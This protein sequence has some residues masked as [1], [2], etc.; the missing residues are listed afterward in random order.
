MLVLIPTLTPIVLFVRLLRPLVLIRFGA[1][2]S[3][4]FGLL[5]FETEIYLCERDAG[6]HGKRVLDLFY[7]LSP[8]CNQQ[9]KKMW[10]RALPVSRLA[11]W[12]YKVN[13]KLPG[14][15]IHV[16]PRC[17]EQERDVHGLLART[18]PHISFTAKEERQGQASLREM[19]IPE[20]DPFV[21]FHARDSAYVAA[22]S[23]TSVSSLLYGFR[24][25]SIRNYVPAAAELA[26]RGCFAV[27]L[28]SVVKDPLDTSNPMIIDYATKHRSDFL[29]VYLGAR[30]RFILCSSNGIFAVPATFRRP[31]AM[32]NYVPLEFVHTW[33]PND[34]FIPRKLWLPHERRYLTFREILE[35]R[36]G[37][38]WENQDYKALGIEIIENTPE[39]ITALAV[40]MDER[41]KGTW[42]TTDEDEHLQHCFWSLFKPSNLHGEFL[43]RIGADFLRE[44]RELLDGQA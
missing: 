2:R 42:V 26:R 39:E 30:C 1:L 31:V 24:D 19:G 17:T 15:A 36:I 25:C 3:N 11:A 43:S 7:H 40:E 21:C 29:D 37:Q 33:N 18:Q 35:S 23:P 20:S 27:R 10:D 22:F 28:G 8:I 16:I 38:F 34:M 32:A 13:H 5:A 44:N 12:L 9:L 6:M 4:V 14:G 41:L